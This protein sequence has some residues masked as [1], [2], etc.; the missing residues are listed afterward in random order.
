MAYGGQ[1]EIF[2]GDPDL[3]LS[4]KATLFCGCACD[5]LDIHAHG[6]SASARTSS[7]AA[8]HLDQP[9]EQAHDPLHEVP[10]QPEDPG[11]QSANRF[12]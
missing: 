4:L 8:R 9:P 11:E 5:D 10:E 6:R 3:G 1:G 7:L 12:Q 2:D